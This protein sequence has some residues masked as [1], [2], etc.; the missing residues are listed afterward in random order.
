MGGE[1]IHAG[2]P[3]AGV[4][5]AMVS[6]TTRKINVSRDQSGRAAG[7]HRAR[8]IVDAQRAK[9]LD[10]AVRGRLGDRTLGEDT[11]TPVSFLGI[12]PGCHNPFGWRR[13]CAGR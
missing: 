2:P 6:E 7:H 12:P 10:A 11:T 8:R 3:Q 5:A 9:E 13:C 4:R 1:L